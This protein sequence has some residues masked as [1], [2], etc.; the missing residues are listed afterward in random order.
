MLRDFRRFARVV[1]PVLALAMASA[2][3]GIK[4]PLTLPAKASPETGAE[5]AQSQ[6]AE[7]KP[8]AP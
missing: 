5:P 1:L 2:S 4:G 6:P 3:C 7:R 8:V